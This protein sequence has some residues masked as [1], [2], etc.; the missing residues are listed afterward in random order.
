MTFER[1]RLAAY[2][3]T[4][5]NFIRLV[6]ELHNK[7]P[8]P[9]PRPFEDLT[10]YESNLE[11]LRVQCEFNAN[12]DTRLK[13]G[14]LLVQ[15]AQKAKAN[16]S[17]II[18]WQQA[19]NRSISVCRD[20]VQEFPLSAEAHREL[21]YCLGL[22]AEAFG[23]IDDHID[24][25]KNLYRQAA[26]LGIPNIQRGHDHLANL[27]AAI[28]R[29][30]EA[31]EELDLHPLMRQHTVFY[32]AELLVKNADYNRALSKLEEYEQLCVEDDSWPVPPT[33]LENL[34]ASISA[35]LNN[36]T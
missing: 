21:A 27:Y 15:Y 26:H 17:A 2:T 36:Q 31:V 29:Y 13:Y 24:E 33:H 3:L 22:Y 7:L 19:A 25:I 8:L 16:P 1:S 9:L 20:T 10:S 4:M 32:Q 23:T 34:R 6:P 28:G 35:G 5:N 18:D 11:E 14:I 30:G 12:L